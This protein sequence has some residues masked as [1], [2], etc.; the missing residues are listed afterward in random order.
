[1]FKI[2]VATRVISF[3]VL[4]T[5]LFASFA[6][7]GAL[8]KG[9]NQGLESKWEQLVDSYNR[10]SMTHNSAHHWAEV[11]L[12]NNPDVSASKKAAVERHLTICN[13]ALAKAT[14]IVSKH[15]GFD[16]SGKVVDKAAAQ[17]SAKDLTLVLQ[18]HAA[19]I[20]RLDAHVNK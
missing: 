6:T 16:S 13:T 7:I 20:R 11:W 17:K 1:M 12:K 3:A 19:S 4:I 18:Q 10:Q 2:S 8:A 15:N 5:L 14:A 9:N